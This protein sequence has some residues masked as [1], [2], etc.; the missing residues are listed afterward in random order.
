MGS[1]AWLQYVLFL[2]RFHPPLM[3]NNNH[4]FLRSNDNL[5][6]LNNSTNTLKRNLSSSV[7]TTR[8]VFDKQ[9]IQ[10]VHQLL[11]EPELKRARELCSSLWLG[12]LQKAIIM[13]TNRAF[14]ATGD[15]DEMWIRDSSVQVGIYCNRHTPLLRSIVEATLRQQ[16]AFIIIDPYANAYSRV[17]KDMQHQEAKDAVIGR[18][19]WVGTRNYELDSGAYFLHALWD[20]YQGYEYP[21]GLLLETDMVHA[22]MVMINLWITEQHHEGR[23]LYRYFELPR[24]GK[25]PLTN[26]TGMTWSGFR[27]SDNPCEYGYLI[28]A[29][30]HAAA[31][32]E[33]VLIL[34]EE[35]WKVPSLHQKAN[36]LLHDITEGIQRF[37][38]VSTS[39][40]DA[41]YA[42][43]VDGLGNALVNYDDANVPS[44]L[45]LPLLGWS[46]L[47]RT[48]YDTTRRRILSP[49]HNQWY[50]RGTKFSGIGSSHT[51]QHHIWPL[52][53]AMQALTSTTAQEVVFQLRQLMQSAACNH[54]MHESIHMNDGCMKFTRSW[55]E[56]ANALYV[57]LVEAALGESCEA[58]GQELLQYRH[59]EVVQKPSGPIHFYQNIH[60]NNAKQSNYYLGIEGAVQYAKDSGF[61]GKKG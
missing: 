21:Q 19:G 42:Y 30:I 33:R 41:V 43:E 7:W 28:P 15:I 3:E 53:L 31:A 52:A 37:G 6:S 44:L 59:S 11:S 2:V 32:L 34:N 4:S 12:S 25:G 17:F 50:F 60:R 20:Y 47:N 39:E 29:N 51:P 61:V 13:S 23:S 10:Q 27:P 35:L 58:T 5:A 57:V 22:V 54:V 16:A 8:Q 9:V 45:S 46:G 36:Q 48:V 24:D 18:G 1:I 49:K 55:F 26:Y 56:W 40:G 38:I 14:V